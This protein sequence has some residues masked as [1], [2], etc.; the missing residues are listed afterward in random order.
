MYS[1]G[2]SYSRCCNPSVS[3]RWS[4]LTW[5][6]VRWQNPLKQSF[7]TLLFRFLSIPQLVL[8]GSWRVCSVHITIEMGCLRPVTI[9]YREVGKSG[10]WIFLRLPD[11]WVSVWIFHGNLLIIVR[12]PCHNHTDTSTLIIIC[13]IHHISSN[14]IE[15]LPCS[16]HNLIGTF[17]K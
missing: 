11:C 6:Y 15:S 4:R 13:F 14:A 10:I 17:V 7:S 2:R 8:F 5:S 1:T 3:A 12:T 16:W 9:R